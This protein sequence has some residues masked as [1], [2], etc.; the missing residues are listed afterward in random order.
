[1]ATKEGKVVVTFTFQ[2]TNENPKG[3]FEGAMVFESRRVEGLPRGWIEEEFLY[4]ELRKPNEPWED[5][6]WEDEP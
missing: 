6:P 2:Y 3:D 4:Q 5:E 1:M